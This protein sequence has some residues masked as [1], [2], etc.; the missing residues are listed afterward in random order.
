MFVISSNLTILYI[1]YVPF[2]TDFLQDN[3]NFQNIFSEQGNDNEDNIDIYDD[4]DLSS[5]YYDPETFSSEFK[6]N[7]NLS[8]LSLNVL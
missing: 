6:E 2:S 1:N 8:V 7:K 4:I 3:F 5:K